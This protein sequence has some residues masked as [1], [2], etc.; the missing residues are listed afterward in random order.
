MTRD[1]APLGPLSLSASILNRAMMTL[2]LK[3]LLMQ[4]L[5]SEIV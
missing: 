4:L 5:L 1:A 3:Q 2:P